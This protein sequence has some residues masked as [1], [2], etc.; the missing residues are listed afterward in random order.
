MFLKPPKAK[1]ITH[2]NGLKTWEDSYLYFNRGEFHP[3]V[4]KINYIVPSCE[5]ISLD[6]FP[7]EGFDD[8]HLA[9]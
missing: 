2:T 8:H 7:P 9:E 5:M 1:G 3:I 6:F 4:V